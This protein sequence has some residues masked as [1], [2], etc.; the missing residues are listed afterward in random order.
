MAQQQKQFHKGR[1]WAITGLLFLLLGMVCLVGRFI[2]RTSIYNTLTGL[3]SATAIE[4][5]QESYLT[6][7]ELAPEKAEA[8]SLLLDTYAE[9][10][11]YTKQEAEKYLSIYNTYNGK[12]YNNTDFGQL[13]TKTGLLYINGYDDSFTSSL[14]MAYPFFQQAVELLPEEDENYL[15]ANIY[16]NIGTYY[17]EY[18][19]SATSTKD[20]SNEQM[21]NLIQEIADYCTLLKENPDVTVYDKLGFYLAA[22]NLLID[23]R[24]VIVKTCSED[25]ISGIFDTIYTGLPSSD[26]LQKEKTKDMLETLVSGEETY[27][28]M[29][30]RAFTRSRGGGPE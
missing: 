20:I 8:Y 14:R 2:Y 29:I 1:S 30:S 16:Y 24:N 27:R 21:T 4:Q 18:I 28:Q 23:Q 7:I 19:W 10:G 25:L 3:S 17:Q 9:D 22:C 26:S 15:S 11:I 5:R 12:W 6:A 13:M